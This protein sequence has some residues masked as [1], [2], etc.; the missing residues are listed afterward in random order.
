MSGLEFEKEVFETFRVTA[1]RVIDAETFAFV[2]H[3]DDA[4]RVWQAAA[5]RNETLPVRFVSGNTTA[6][7]W[8]SFNFLDG[9]SY[10]IGAGQNPRGNKQALF[11]SVGLYFFSM[12]YSDGPNDME[13]RME[14][15]TSNSLE[16]D[17][18]YR[19]AFLRSRRQEAFGQAHRPWPVGGAELCRDI[20]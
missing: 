13:G 14:L 15:A 20:Q 16:G 7:R 9:A 3:A 5:Q 11:G 4:D 10:R 18:V 19:R 1:A 17:R 8:G 2:L 6:G 12:E